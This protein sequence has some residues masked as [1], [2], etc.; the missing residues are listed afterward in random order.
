MRIKKVIFSVMTSC[1]LLFTAF[2]A[3]AGIPTWDWMHI[4]LTGASW[5]KQAQ[6]MIATAKQYQ[7]QIEQMTTM[8]EKLDGGRGLG[9]A[10]NNPDINAS[11]P[12]EMRNIS[13]MIMNPAELS[14]SPGSINS[15]LSSFGVSTTGSNGQ[16]NADQLGK[17]QAI[18][19]AAQK[20]QTQIG[21]LA[22]Q[23]DSS[24]DAKSSLD[25]LNRNALEAATINNQIMQTMASI[26]ATRQAEILR[27]IS[28]HQRLWKAEYEAAKTPLP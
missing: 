25:L 27:K 10:F 21:S 26:E 9:T 18:L 5:A 12:G 23:V 6:D 20:R 13:A 1:A 22:T 11:L 19:T 4:L 7:A 14:T 15:I 3:H 28:E 16:S 2:P 17:M 24:A 8:T